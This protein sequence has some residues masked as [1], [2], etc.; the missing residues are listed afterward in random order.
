VNNMQKH[1]LRSEPKEP[2]ENKR[3]LVNSV[4]STITNTTRVGAFTS[5][6]LRDEI[7]IENSTVLGGN[8]ETD[9][10]FQFAAGSELFIKTSN[11]LPLVDANGQLLA[12][13]NGQAFQA[14]TTTLSFVKP[15]LTNPSPAQV[16]AFAQEEVRKRNN[17]IVGAPHVTVGWGGWNVTVGNT[18]GAVTKAAYNVGGY[19]ALLWSENDQSN[20]TS[21]YTLVE[22]G[23]RGEDVVRVDGAMGNLTL[24]VSASEDN[25]T[26]VAM[27][28]RQGN[29]ILGVG[30]DTD[31]SVATKQPLTTVNLSH[32]FTESNQSFGNISPHEIGVRFS[33]K[34]GVSGVVAHA[35][36][37]IGSGNKLYAFG[38][39]QLSGT[40]QKI[41]K[42]VAGAVWSRNL[43]GGVVGHLGTEMTEIPAVAAAGGNPATPKRR[44][45]RFGLGFELQF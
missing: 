25:D 31:D 44:D 10:G 34:D 40:N 39:E 16:I 8:T 18:D 4:K 13:Q 30:Y 38:G 14:A 36:V 1:Y 11:R 17:G 24:S 19:H 22:Q 12:D 32:V 29:Y 37:D 35:A 7:C 9:G 45:T 21:S 41:Q 3:N 23:G 33:N 27:T 20:D 5:E 28:Y 6:T 42:T 2:T 43:G 26:E 15:E